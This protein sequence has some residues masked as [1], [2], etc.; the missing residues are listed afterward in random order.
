MNIVGARTIV[1]LAAGLVLLAAPALSAEHGEGGGHFGGG[2]FGGENFGGHFDAPHMEDHFGGDHI[3]APDHAL[4]DHFHGIPDF[5][6]RDFGHFSPAEREMWTGGRWVHDWHDGR[7]GW[8]WTL[9]DD[10][11]FYPEPIYPYPSYVAPA[12]AGG[13]YYCANPPG[14]YPSV[15]TCD[16]PWQAVPAV[17]PPP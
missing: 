2:H 9:G 1:G 4:A 10:W 11:Y 7:L 6:G 3:G 14:Y 16:A 13:S 15:Q 5:H 12:A 8:W 17:V